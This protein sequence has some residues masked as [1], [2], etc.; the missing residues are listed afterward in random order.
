MVC[1]ADEG[2]TQRKSARNAKELEGAGGREAKCSRADIA[3]YF[4]KT[5]LWSFS[6]WSSYSLYRAT[7]E[8]L[9]E[10]GHNLSLP[11]FGTDSIIR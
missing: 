11:V 10:M 2:G 8:N 1:A 5:I 3:P 4:D 7:E 9:K 6:I